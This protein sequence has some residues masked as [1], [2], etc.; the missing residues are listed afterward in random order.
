MD[1]EILTKNNLK[2]K[3]LIMHLNYLKEEK[4]LLMH[5][6]MVSFHYVNNIDMKNGQM[7]NTKKLRRNT[8]RYA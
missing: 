5:L 7:K 4:R 6:K 1:Q 8:K 2:K 3:P